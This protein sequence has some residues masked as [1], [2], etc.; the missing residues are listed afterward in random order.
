MSCDECGKDIGP[1]S[2]CYP[3]V[4]D[5]DIF[6]FCAKCVHKFDWIFEKTN[7]KAE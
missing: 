5:G 4:L 3:L 6:S 7:W 2:K 1:R